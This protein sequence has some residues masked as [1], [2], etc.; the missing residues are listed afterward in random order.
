LHQ[1]NADPSMRLTTNHGVPIS[2]NQNAL[3]A[4]V[5]GPELLEDFILREKIHQFD[6]ERIPERIVMHAARRHMVILN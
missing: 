4:G 1:T 3:K 2:D 6:H 5:R